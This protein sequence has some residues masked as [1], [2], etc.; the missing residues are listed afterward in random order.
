MTRVL[1]VSIGCVARAATDE[2]TAPRAA[3]VQS[4]GRTAY[5]F[6]HCIA[7]KRSRERGMLP[8]FVVRISWV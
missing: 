3:S 5:D 2:D 4:S 7:M 8:L 1:T 6:R